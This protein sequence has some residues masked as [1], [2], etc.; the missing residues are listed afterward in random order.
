MTFLP[1][2]GAGP[3]VG[4]FYQQKYVFGFLE[5]FGVVF[6]SRTLV[7]MVQGQSYE[8]EAPGYHTF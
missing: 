8:I 2:V 5:V 7:K 1:K 6:L 4:F 3:L